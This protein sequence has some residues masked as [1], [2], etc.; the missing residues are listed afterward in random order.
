MSF[1]DGTGILREYYS[2]SNVPPSERR[3][4][5]FSNFLLLRMLLDDL[6]SGVE[7]S[8]SNAMKRGGDDSR[9]SLSDWS[10]SPR[11]MT[12]RGTIKRSMQCPIDNREIHDQ[13][14]TNECRM[15][16]FGDGGCEVGVEGEWEVWASV[17]VARGVLNSGG[18]CR[19]C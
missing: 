4:P 17:T 10:G 2:N 16:S 8:D 15:L 1:S 19:N 6:S 5:S 18:F 9:A 14:R 12:P 7:T 3:S 13:K 11:S